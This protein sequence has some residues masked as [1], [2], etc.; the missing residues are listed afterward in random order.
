[1]IEMY[2]ASSTAAS[3][4]ASSDG[5]L[6]DKAGVYSWAASQLPEHNLHSTP[7]RTKR[8]KLRCNELLLVYRG[9]GFARILAHYIC[10]HE[11]SVGGE[12]GAVG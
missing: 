1:M 2:Y 10:R 9:S 3:Q 4:E 12:D 7:V 11:P 6:Q 5:P 8:E